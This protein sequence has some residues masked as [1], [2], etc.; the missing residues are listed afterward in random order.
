MMASL[1]AV[2]WAQAG[3]DD[4][5]V[6][7][8]PSPPAVVERMLEM[9]DAAS[10]DKLYD[11]GSGDGR[12]VVAAA[13]DFGVKRAVGVEIDRSLVARSREKARAEGVADRTRFVQGD[14]FQYD[15]SDADAVTLFLLPKLNRRLRP[16]LLAELEP[17]TRVVS[18]EH[19]MGDWRPDAT[20]RVDGHAIYRWTI[21]ARLE[22]HWRWRVDG[23]RY[24]L[25]LQQHYQRVYGMLRTDGERAALQRA[26]LNGRRL[27]W[28]ATTADGDT[29]RFKG[30]ARGDTLEGELVAGDR[31][32][33][34]RARRAR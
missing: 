7:Y 22:G 20:D 28:R 27:E 10:A 31:A 25:E 32:V 30:R 8:D 2:E 33:Q 17:G 34:V 23:T 14:L 13:R 16:R 4:A 19:R 18:H 26:R 11:L 21:P 24:E 9:V 6:R 5:D 1:A 3:D 12:I 15:F 29:L